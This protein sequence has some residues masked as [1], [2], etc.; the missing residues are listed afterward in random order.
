MTEISG[1]V[2]LNGALQG[3]A[4]LILRQ[5]RTAHVNERLQNFAATRNS[6]PTFYPQVE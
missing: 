1:Y 4:T 2:N 3:Y 6:T 5:L